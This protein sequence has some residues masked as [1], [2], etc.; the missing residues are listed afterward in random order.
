L[1]SC[2]PFS[3]DHCDVC[4]SLI[5]GFRLHLWY[6]Q[7]LLVI[8]FYP[9]SFGHCDVCPSLTYGFRLHLWYLQALLM[10]DLLLSFF[11][12]PLWCM[13]FCY[14]RFL[15]TPLVSSSSS[16]DLL[17]E[18]TCDILTDYLHFLVQGTIHSVMLP[19]CDD[20]NLCKYTK[21]YHSAEIIVI[22]WNKL[23]TERCY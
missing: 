23:C 18:L 5:Y 13:S 7:A 9:F 21:Q 17:C 22:T 16:Y 6:L 3:F 15:I 10:I 8:S 2:C 20:S 19:D 4:L 11:F 14:L 1:I 12:W